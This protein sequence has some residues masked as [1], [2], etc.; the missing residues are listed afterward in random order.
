MLVTECDKEGESGAV[1]AVGAVGMV[2]A[3]LGAVGM[4]GAVG[5][6]VG[7]LSDKPVCFQTIRDCFQTRVSLPGHSWSPLASSCDL[8]MEQANM[9]HCCARD[10]LGGH[11]TVAIA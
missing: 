7:E 3:V 11:F 4:V 9:R 10:G 8:E 5:A 2:G 1:G 6:V